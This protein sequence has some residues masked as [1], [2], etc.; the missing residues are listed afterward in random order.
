[1]LVCLKFHKARYK[2]NVLDGVNSGYMALVQ[3]IAWRM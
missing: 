3:N 1:V 2:L